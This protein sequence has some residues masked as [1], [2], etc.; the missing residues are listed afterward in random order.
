MVISDI[1]M[2]GMSRSDLVE[3]LRTQVPDLPVLFVSGVSS[4]GMH[5]WRVDEVTAY[6]TKSLR[7]DAV[8]AR[9]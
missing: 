3:R 8:A 4:E 6:L 7:G 5:D 1:A 2:T 9:V